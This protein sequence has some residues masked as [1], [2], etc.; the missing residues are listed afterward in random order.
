M[1]ALYFPSDV[2]TLAL[3]IIYA[4]ERFGPYAKRGPTLLGCP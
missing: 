4:L 3:T 2:D 1:M